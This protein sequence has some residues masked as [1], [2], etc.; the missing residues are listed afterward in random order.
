MRQVFRQD[1]A[2]QILRD[3]VRRDVERQTTPGA[4]LGSA[5]VTAERLQAMASELGV[6]QEVLQGV[7]RDREIAA[8]QQRREASEGE[9]RQEFITKR[10]AEFV[11][12]LYSYLGVN[13][14]LAGIWFLNG[15]NLHDPWFL[16]IML[17]WG[18]GIYF[19]AVNA[20]PTRGSLFDKE[21]TEYKAKRHRRSER[22][23]KRAARDAD[24]AARRDAEAELDE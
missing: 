8:E 10:R 22:K 9:V 7:L 6:S 14:M 12:D 4:S 16:W 3:A 15:H 21:F 24:K 11:S 2:E 20:L 17:F 19:H 13:G 5:E 23:A 18:I 1:E